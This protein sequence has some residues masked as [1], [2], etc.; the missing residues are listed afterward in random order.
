MTYNTMT[1]IK[2]LVGGCNGHILSIKSPNVMFDDKLF[3]VN[4]HLTN[5]RSSNWLGIHRLGI[6]LTRSHILVL[7]VISRL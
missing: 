4:Y 3:R 1:K 7:V 5:W 6:D 2:G